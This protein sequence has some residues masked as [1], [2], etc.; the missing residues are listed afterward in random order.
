VTKYFYHVSDGCD[1]IEDVEGTDLPGIDDAAIEAV[2][3]AREIVAER[4]VHG[5]VV[6]GQK[7]CIATALGDI[8]AVV[9][10]KNVFASQ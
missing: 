9:A 8:V 7:F 2:E 10:F 6:G 3:I 4:L 1:F 5:L